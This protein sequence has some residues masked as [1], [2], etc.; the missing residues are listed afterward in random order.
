MLLMVHGNIITGYR[1][2]IAPC[3]CLV[4]VCAKMKNNKKTAMRTLFITII[5]MAH[6]VYATSQTLTQTVKGK[7]LD[8]ETQIALPGAFVSINVAG[9]LTSASSDGNGNF[10]FE[11][12]PLGR[13]SLKVNYVGYEDV[14]VSDMLVNSGKEVVLNIEMK[15]QVTN[16]KEVVVKAN[17]EKDKS[18]NSMA[19][20]SARMFSV[21]ET[22]RYAGGFDDPGRLASAFAGVT[23]NSDIE[24]NGIIV[25][26]NSPTGVLW[27]VEGVEVPNPNHFAG[28]HMLGGG[29]VTFF[30]NNML[31]NSDFLTGAF[32]SE[33]GN[34]LSA[35]FDI[36][37]RTGNNEKYEHSLGAG[38]MGIDIA[39]EGPLKKGKASY[40]FNYRYSTFGLLSS[41]MPEGEGLPVYQDLCFKFNFPTAKFGTFSFWGVGALDDFYKKAETDSTAWNMAQKRQDNDAKFKTSIGGVTHKI[42]FGKKSY[43]QSSVS[44]S[45]INKT[46]TMKFLENNMEY[47]TRNHVND[48]EGRVTFSSFINT[49]IHAN[50]INRTGFIFSSLFYD[51]S[52]ESSQSANVSLEP[53]TAGKGQAQRFQAYTQSKIDITSNISVNAGL[54]LHYFNLNNELSVEP[55]AGIR[56]NFLPKQGLS[57]AYGNHSQLQEL[58]IYFISKKDNDGNEMNNKKLKFSRAHHIILGYDLKI[59]QNL[60]LKLE[61]YY[62]YLYNL[63]VIEDSSF[64]FI[65]VE[66]IYNINELLVNKGTGRNIGVDITFERFLDKGFYYLVTAS[67]FDSKY[68]GGD[69]IERNTRFNKH[70]VGN[71]LGGKEWILGSSKNN[72]L[73]LNGRLY[74]IGG[75]KISPIDYT[76]S[77]AEEEVVYD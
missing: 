49:K 56:W 51:F 7:V 13:H 26:G 65:N 35:V 70:F 55:R 46:A 61:P 53:I 67:V 77:L 1:K 9:Q 20:L 43:M 24:N 19:T 36:K 73:G 72:I 60:R 63:P 14:L 33:Y 32:P 57:F 62:Q 39:S 2:K 8:K 21:E 3:F 15:E 52:D 23:T 48:N 27:R 37:L 11:N 66:E 4:Y 54:H 68:K 45:Y 16:L 10:R 69:G 41:F 42:T 58:S 31:S 34:G 18:I 38:V 44:A 29:F 50:H 28:A 6:L 76:A 25:R 74:L 12:I 75:D 17:N 5:L 30:S 47:T 22:R 64:A 40:I 59:N 71:I